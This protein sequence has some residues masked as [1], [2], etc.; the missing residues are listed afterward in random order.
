M[1]MTSGSTKKTSH[2]ISSIS[3]LLPRNHCFAS[4]QLCM[5]QEQFHGKRTTISQF[6]PSHLIVDPTDL[7]APVAHHLL[8]LYLSDR[9]T[10]HTVGS[11]AWTPDRTKRTDRH[12]RVESS[13]FSLSSIDT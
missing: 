9:R 13:R 5:S 3:F 10:P 2:Q 12:R 4:P 7:V 11:T 8:L 1:R 6:G